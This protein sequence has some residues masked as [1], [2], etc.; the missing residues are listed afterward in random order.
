MGNTAFLP[1]SALTV[2]PCF[3]SRGMGSEGQIP[4]QGWRVPTPMRYRLEPGP[5]GWWPFPPEAG[6][7]KSGCLCPTRGETRPGS[8]PSITRERGLG[9]Q[10]WCSSSSKAQADARRKEALTPSAGQHMLGRQKVIQTTLQDS[11]REG[12]LA[13]LSCTYRLLRDCYPAGN[14]TDSLQVCGPGWR[15]GGGLGRHCQRSSWP[16]LHFHPKRLNLSWRRSEPA[17]K[18]SKFK[19]SRYCRW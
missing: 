6:H 17:A 12:G 1:P 11:P 10:R 5:R 4:W 7:S 8:I 13:K 19:S 2:F 9:G 14:S 3:G 16:L 15:G 18:E